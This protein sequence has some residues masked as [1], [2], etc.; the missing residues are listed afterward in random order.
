MASTQKIKKRVIISKSVATRWLQDKATPEYRFYVM[1]S[2]RYFTSLLR[3]F[4]DGKLRLASVKPLPDL[5]LQESSQG[6]YVWSS[7]LEGLKSLQEYF[8]KYNIETSWIW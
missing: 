7:N 2:P 6:F 4:R 5:G 1:A 3:S 8:A